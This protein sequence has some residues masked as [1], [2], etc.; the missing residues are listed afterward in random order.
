MQNQ[1][2]KIPIIRDYGYSIIVFF[3]YD[4]Y[5]VSFK[6]IN[7]LSERI[8]GRR[9]FHKIGFLYLILNCFMKVFTDSR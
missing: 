4:V 3:E 7:V 5:Y 8:H 1:I 9:K 2:N 6:L